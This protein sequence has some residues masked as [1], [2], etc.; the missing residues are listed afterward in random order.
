VW[1]GQPK[2]VSVRC[3]RHTGA[4]CESRKQAQRVGEMFFSSRHNG[5]IY[6]ADERAIPREMRAKAL[7]PFTWSHCPFC[8][9]MLPD[10]LSALDKLI[11]EPPWT[12]EDGG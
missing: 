10:I 1:F 3:N 5:W 7:A 9:G 11:E 12:G 6:P 2:P 8:N 4:V